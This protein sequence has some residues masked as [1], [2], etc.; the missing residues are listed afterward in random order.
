MAEE[1]RVQVVGRHV[2]SKTG[3]IDE[4]YAFVGNDAS[5]D[6]WRY[7]FRGMQMNPD[8]LFFALW[9]KAKGRL[10]DWREV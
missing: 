6:E 1:I 5:P 2:R 4:A 7:Y 10:S 9:L 3:E 8:T